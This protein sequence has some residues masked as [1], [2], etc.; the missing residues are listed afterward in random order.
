MVADIEHESSHI[1]DRDNSVQ[2]GSLAGSAL[3]INLLALTTLILSYIFVSEPQTAGLRE[4]STAWRRMGFLPA[5]LV[6]IGIGSAS[7]L[8]FCREIET[9]Y[10]LAL[11]TTWSVMIGMAHQIGL[12]TPI[13]SDGWFFVELSLRFQEF[14]FENVINGYLQRPLSLLLVLIVGTVPFLTYPLAASI[15]GLVIALCTTYLTLNHILTQEQTSRYILPLIGAFWA[16]LVTT[17]GDLF[18]YEAHALGVLILFWFW[19]RFSPSQHFVL[20]VVIICVLCM[21]HFFI[22]LILIL[23]WFIQ[24]LKEGDH[25]W[26][27][28]ALVGT[29]IWSLWGF[30]IAYDSTAGV[31]FRPLNN[32]PSNLM[33]SLMIISLIL[34]ILYIDRRISIS[35]EEAV[36][37]VSISS[38][39]ILAS[40]SIITPFFLYQDLSLDSTGL[41]FTK[42]LLLYVFPSFVIL[43]LHRFSHGIG[44]LIGLS[45]G[46]LTSPLMAILILMVSISSGITHHRWVGRDNHFHPQTVDCWGLLEEQG[47]EV[48]Q[49]STI[50]YLVIHSPQLVPPEP[51]YLAYFYFSPDNLSGNQ[52]QEVAVVL[53]T[54]DINHRLNRSG[55]ADQVDYHNWLMIDEIDSICR[56]WV[57][58]EYFDR[59]S[60]QSD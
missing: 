27:N 39:A 44:H 57:H 6:G 59:K 20:G 46:G 29:V 56:L 22:P 51:T 10:V 55:F 11:S 23:S 36:T 24:W 19:F 17:I 32:A 37:S 16:I 47:M 53:E 50:R 8:A 42:R 13:G 3:V 2:Y 31:L 4:S 52:P 14:G 45:S 58:P 15:L 35:K 18:D 33:I 25:H 41:S 30:T 54:P 12:G 28:I 7:F 5:I 1:S 48:S 26:R 40:C 43:I 60:N 21:T 38:T 34:F 9:R 49:R